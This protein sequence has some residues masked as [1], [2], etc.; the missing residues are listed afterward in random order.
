MSAASWAV[1]STPDW[2]CRRARVRRRA[3]SVKKG[4]WPAVA[5]SARACS[6]PQPAATAK[7]RNS[8]AVP[9]PLSSSRR[10]RAALWARARSG[11]TNPAMAVASQV[12]AGQAPKGVMPSW[13]SSGNSP[14]PTRPP[15]S[16]WP[17]CRAGPPGSPA[18]ASRRASRPVGSP[19]TSA[20][21]SSRRPAACRGGTRSRSRVGLAKEVGGG[22]AGR[23]SGRRL[24]SRW[25]RVGAGRPTGWATSSTRSPIPA[26][27]GHQMTC[28]MAGHPL[29]WDGWGGGGCRLGGGPGAPSPHS[30]PRSAPARGRGWPGRWGCR[31]GPGRR[32]W[33]GGWRAG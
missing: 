19:H 28:I 15:R 30:R 27:S 25:A 24:A 18:N 23:W 29:A 26:T 32:G 16:F 9:S 31:R 11:A 8:V 22:E 4:P 13:V 1:A 2:P 5:A 10:R 12:Q 7:A 20:A 21:R 3:S 33:S 14:S 6:S 17:A